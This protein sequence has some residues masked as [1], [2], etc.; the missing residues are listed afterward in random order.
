MT[1]ADNMLSILWML[2]SGR[3]KT[4]K[5]LAEALDIHVRTVYR[6]I[7]S[8]C[9][10]GV[11]I[12]ADSGPNGGYTILSR[13]ADSPLVFDADEQ[14][15]LVHA[16]IFAKEAGYPH[17]DALDRATDKLKRYANDE[18]LD[19]LERHGLGLSVIEPPLDGAY[20]SYLQS[21]EEAAGKGRTLEMDYDK[22]RGETSP[23]R[24]FDPYGI[25]YWKGTWYAVGLCGYREDV[26]SFRVDRIRGLR[27]TDR[28]FER[29]ASFSAKD[30]LLGQL[31][32]D[33]K[34]QA[35][36]ETVR[37]HSQEQVLNELCRHW[38]FGHA[39]TER[40]LETATF[41]LERSTLT[42]YVPYFLM[43]YG[44]A[45]RIES[46]LLVSRMREATARLLVHY[47]AM[48]SSNECGEVEKR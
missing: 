12:V 26:R 44:T 4:A 31:L 17:S 14:K 29:P 1:K 47:E 21:L 48:Q 18:Q 36:W 45:L 6:C 22:G 46:A 7:D 41:R 10:S 38:L 5:Q 19:A 27:Q 43:P 34:D 15:G 16:A 8:L 32:R 35:E 39:L 42:T 28:R 25:V 13:F 33:S 3:R 23:A 37:I 24:L 2:R 40:E 30:Y 9:A 11:P 20:Q